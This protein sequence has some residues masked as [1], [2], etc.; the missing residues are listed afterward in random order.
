MKMIQRPLHNIKLIDY[1]FIIGFSVFII[2][3]IALAIPASI[4]SSILEAIS[5]VFS[6]QFIEVESSNSLN[7][8]SIQT[9]QSVQNRYHI[10]NVLKVSLWIMGAILLLGFL[11]KK[12]EDE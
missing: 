4:R 12:S 9:E 6:P 8:T 11:F 7:S 2:I 1:K 10:L 5:F 3:F